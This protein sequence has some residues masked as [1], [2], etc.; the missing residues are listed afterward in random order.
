MGTTKLGAKIPRKLYLQLRAE[1]KKNDAQH[2]KTFKQYLTKL[3][4]RVAK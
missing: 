2:G 1:W 4:E 3:L